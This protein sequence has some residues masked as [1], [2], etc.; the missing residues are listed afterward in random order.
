MKFLVF[1]GALCL[2]LVFAGN[3]FAGEVTLRWNAN[4]ETDLSGYNVYYG[5]S[6]RRYGAPVKIGKKTS[7]TISNLDTGT[8]YYFSITALDTGGNESGY[9][10]EI[11]AAAKAAATT[12]KTKVALWWTTY[13]NR[14]KAV[15]VKIYDGSTLLA[16]VKVNQRLNGGKWNTLGS[17]TFKSTPKVRVVANG[18]GTVCADAVRVTKPDGTKIIVDNGDRATSKTG[19][20][21]ASS[22][23]KYYGRK[24]VYAKDDANYTFTMK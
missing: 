16:R 7:C 21:M 12:A 23:A 13:S 6:S 4:G 20:W 8:N 2:T 19:T 18:T 22:G 1:F 10:A 14:S 9:S 3:L 11:K 15:L 5:K 17:Y 24:S